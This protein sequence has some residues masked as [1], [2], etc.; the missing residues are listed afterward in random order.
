MNIFIY[1]KTTHTRRE[2]S[3]TQLGER[4]D[5]GLPAWSCLMPVQRPAT[6]QRVPS[7]GGSSFT[8]FRERTLAG[9]A[10][11]LEKQAGPWCT[12]FERASWA[13]EKLLG[14]SDAEAADGEQRRR[15]G[16]L[17]DQLK[18]CAER[19]AAALTTVQHTRSQAAAL[20]QCG[21][22]MASLERECQRL[23]ESEKAA[24]E[25]EE[26][27]DQELVKLRAGHSAHVPSSADEGELARLRQEVASLKEECTRL[28][29]VAEKEMCQRFDVGTPSHARRV[30]VAPRVPCNPFYRAC[31]RIARHPPDSAVCMR[32]IGGWGTNPNPRPHLNPHPNPHP[33]PDVSPDPGPDPGPCIGCQGA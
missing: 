6:A 17:L 8:G 22:K 26:K 23:Q 11:D 24:R 12:S 21:D 29:G 1:K 33:N 30:G 20:A 9:L 31:L 25:A 3:P 27:A 10:E 7:N 15:Q 4:L 32:S 19:L 18:L 13:V 16:E 14:I 28:S 5:K 2:V